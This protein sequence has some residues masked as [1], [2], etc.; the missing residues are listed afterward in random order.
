M[1]DQP[2]GEKVLPPSQRK[3]QQARQR[4]NVA[5]SADLNSGF[6]LLVA[7][8]AMYAFGPLAFGQMLAIMRFFMGGTESI[9]AEP[10]SMQGLL[11]QTLILT[12]PVVL[13]LM[14]VLLVAGVLM[15]VVQFG[16]MFSSEAL[17]PRLERLDPIKGFQRLVSLRALV[18]LIKSLLKFAA[19]SIVVYFALRNR[20]P[21]MFSLMHLNAWGATIGMFDLVW[22]VWW[23]VAIAMLVIGVLDYAYQRWQYLQDQRMTRQESQE[24]LKQLEGDPRIR[25]RVRQIQRQMATQRMMAEIPEAD[26]VIT[27]PTTFAVALR[28][29]PD[30]M[31]SPTVTAKG[32]RLIAER[33]RDRAVEFDVPIVE[34]PE[35]ARSLFRDVDI[36]GTVPEQLFRAVAEVLAYVYQ[37]DR[38][39]EKVSERRSA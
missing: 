26:V 9:E 6:L 3:L 31:D 18:E 10:A 15:N 24:E 11:A 2:A 20:L 28:Y 8:F 21:D 5:R 12:V 16:F 39:A 17:T 7:G 32:A 35:L 13:P 4:G 29:D 38:R 14:L 27:N 30:N 23:R 19:V 25:Q 33:I 22:T 1:A 36:G 34:R 37:I